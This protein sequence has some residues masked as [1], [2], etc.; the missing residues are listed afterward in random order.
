MFAVENFYVDEEKYKRLTEE[1][2][3]RAADTIAVGGTHCGW[4][5]VDILW[6]NENYR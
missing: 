5:Y 3:L 2:K 1:Y 4:V 6:V